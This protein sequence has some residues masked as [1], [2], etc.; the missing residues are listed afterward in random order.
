MTN[1]EKINE[2]QGRQ[3]KIN[4]A[5]EKLKIAAENVVIQFR[6]TTKAMEEFGIIAKS[7]KSNK[8]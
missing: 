8:K 6:A 4:D 5:I 2:D 1:L 3:K 7:L